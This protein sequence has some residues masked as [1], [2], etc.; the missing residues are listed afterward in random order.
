MSNHVSPGERNPIEGKFEEAKT[1]YGL[2]LIQA[3][4][5]STSETWI[6][7]N[8]LVLNLANLSRRVLLWFYFILKY[9]NNRGLLFQ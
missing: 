9:K 7:L 1:R 4:L 3:K 5:R 6:A 2:G 8:I